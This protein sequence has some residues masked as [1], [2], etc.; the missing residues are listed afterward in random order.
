MYNRFSTPLVLSFIAIIF[1]GEAVGGTA[2]VDRKNSPNRKKN[3][4]QPKQFQQQ[5]SRQ[6]DDTGD[7]RVIPWVSIAV[8]LNFLFFFRSF[9][10]PFFDPLG[11]PRRATAST[12]YFTFLAFIYVWLASVTTLT[13]VP[14]VSTNYNVIIATALF[15]YMSFV[16]ISALLLGRLAI[17]CAYYAWLFAM[18]GGHISPPKLYWKSTRQTK[19]DPDLTGTAPARRSN[20]AVLTMAALQKSETFPKL[21]AF[22]RP[23]RRVFKSSLLVS[24]S[25]CLLYAHCWSRSLSAFKASRDVGATVVCRSIFGSL[26]F[27]FPSISYHHDSCSSSQSCAHENLIWLLWA[28]PILSHLFYFTMNEFSGKHHKS[29]RPLTKSHAR[30]RNGEIDESMSNSSLDKEGINDIYDDVHDHSADNEDVRNEWT[31]SSTIQKFSKAKLEKP[32]GALAMVP[33][34][35]IMLIKSGFDILISLHIFLGRFDARRMQV[36]LRKSHN[37]RRREDNDTPTTPDGVF[38]FANSRRHIGRLTSGD[39]AEAGF[40]FDFMSDCGDGFNSSYQISRCLAQPFLAVTTQCSTSKRREMRTLPRGKILVLGG[41]LAYPDPTPES[42]ESRLFR[43]FEDALMP[44]EE[45]R[46]EHISIHKPALPVKSWAMP[47]NGKR[48]ISEEEKKCPE[49]YSGSSVNGSLSSYPGPVAFAIPGNHDWFDG[50]ATYTRYILSRDWLG[51]WLMPQETSYFAIELPRGWWILGMDLALDNDINIEQFGFFADLA[52]NSI[53]HDDNVIIVTHIPFWVLTNYE[54]YPVEPETHLNELMQTHLSG[55]VRLRLAGDLHHYTRHM[56]FTPV[57]NK[58]V[59]SLS[60]TTNSNASSKNEPVLIVSG[61]GGAFLHPTHCFRDEIKVGKDKQKYVRVAAYPSVKV[62]QHLSW[63]NLWQFRWRNWRLD[64]IWFITYFGICSSFFPLCGVYDDYLKYNPTHHLRGLISWGF[65]RMLI[66]LA[67]VFVSG[68]VSLLFT[69]FV[70]AT[71][72]GFTETGQSK[73]SIYLTWSLLHSFAHISSALFCLLFVECMAEFIVKEGLVAP[74]DENSSHSQSCGTGLASSI[75]DE[76]TNHFSHVLDDLHFLS[77]TNSTDVK[78]SHDLCPS[79]RF[80]ERLYDIVSKTFFLLYN[81]A[82]VMKRILSVFDLPGVIGSTH[83]EMCH[84]LCANGMEC[85]YSNNFAVFQQL[86][87]LIVVKY[88]AAMSFY[89]GI[90]AVPIAGNVFGTWLALTLNVLKCQYNEGFSS[91]RLG[92]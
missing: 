29:Y 51:G 41:D 22:H 21:M 89:F 43:T 20:S 63:L 8:L 88:L 16:S 6:K 53:K 10:A 34:F 18:R 13:I 46:K 17:R 45:F 74:Q 86:D 36:A 64:I 42:Y 84:H 14:H 28:G 40:W 58:D 32:K 76:Y 72:L 25:L 75:F 54:N 3:F 90:F 92:E 60:N 70:I 56:P 81:G 31:L 52:E 77:S 65:S 57:Q 47:Y 19:S 9:A 79:S 87:R 33:W 82:P 66:L 68:R 62:S 80:D 44:P 61:G 5:Q 71:V 15:F 39:N 7:R 30:S 11:E 78:G 49:S 73:T 24:A 91:L 26:I 50:L 38:N 83:V 69:L 67:N 35:H 27:V 85:L 12:I 2:I 59:K 1:V 48:E 23:F 37:V 55:R 4:L